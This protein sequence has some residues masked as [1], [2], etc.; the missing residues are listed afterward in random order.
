MKKAQNL[1]YRIVRRAKRE[2]WL[3][4]LLREKELQE[5]D[6]VNIYREDKNRCWK[7]L[8]HTKPRTNCTTPALQG[9]NSEVTITMQAKKALVRAHTFEKAPAFQG[10]EYQPR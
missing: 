1:F 10:N 9:P 5:G 8:K 3:K 2:C 7:A 6:L 4:F